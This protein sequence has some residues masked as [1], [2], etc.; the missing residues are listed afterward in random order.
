MADPRE[1][2]I[3]PHLGGSGVGGD[4]GYSPTLLLAPW[5]S[6]IRQVT[7]PRYNNETRNWANVGTTRKTI[8]PFFLFFSPMMEGLDIADL[9]FLVVFPVDTTNH[10]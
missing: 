2:R 6:T 10:A 5:K 9:D 7:S 8:R 4:F 3:V 1:L